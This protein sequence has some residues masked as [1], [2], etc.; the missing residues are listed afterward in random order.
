MPGM[1]EQQFKD[2]L[3]RYLKNAR[4]AIVWKLDRLGEYDLRRPLVP[5]GNN[6]L[7]LVKH[8][9]NVEFGYFG[10]TFGRPSPDAPS[11]DFDA[12]LQA[13]WIAAPDETSDGIV[14]LYKKA[15]AHSDATIEALPLDTAGHVPWWPADRNEATLHHLLVRVVEETGH[16]GGH[17]DIIRELIDGAAGLHPDRPNLDPGYTT[18]HTAFYDRVERAAREAAGEAARMKPDRP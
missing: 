14:A 16:H 10:D 3:H 17:A 1:G 4:E 6:L 2:D 15:W 11:Y 13:D 12:D 9:T 8:L 7:G 5:T 18:G